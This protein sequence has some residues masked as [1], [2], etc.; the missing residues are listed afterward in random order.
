MK[1]ILIYD[2]RSDCMEKFPVNKANRLY[3]TNN[4]TWIYV[5]LPGE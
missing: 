2:G 5:T 1:I 4:Q 3:S